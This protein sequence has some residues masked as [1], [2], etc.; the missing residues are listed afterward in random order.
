MLR[1]GLISHRHTLVMG[2]TMKTCSRC[3]EEKPF[4]AYCKRSD[5][6]DGLQYHCKSCDT[7][8]HRKERYGINPEEYNQMYVDQ[9][10]K[11]HICETHEDNLP[12]VLCVDHCHETGAVRGLLCR[13]CNLALGMF[14][15]NPKLL[16]RA[17]QYVQKSL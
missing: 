17:L 11:C 14:K 10:G 6:K 8:G 3:K 15:D 5:A 2:S 7:K 16:Q 13:H 9:E 4:E 12:R 1:W